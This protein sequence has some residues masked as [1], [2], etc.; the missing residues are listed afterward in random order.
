VHVTP[1][2]L[3]DGRIRAYLTASHERQKEVDVDSMA[4]SAIRTTSFSGQAVLVRKD[5]YG[6]G[7]RHGTNAEE[8][9]YLA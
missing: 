4:I 8:R 7:H 6:S 5:N 9:G 2:Q 3:S 1:C